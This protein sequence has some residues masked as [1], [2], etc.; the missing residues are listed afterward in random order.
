MNDMQ[1]HKAGSLFA[2][3]V[4]RLILACLNLLVACSNIFFPSTFLPPKVIRNRKGGDSLDE[5]R[6]LRK[7]GIDVLII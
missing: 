7:L 6:P 4:K 5:N 2:T 3:G 1:L